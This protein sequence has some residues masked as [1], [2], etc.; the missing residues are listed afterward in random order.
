MKLK[1]DALAPSCPNTPPSMSSREK[2]LM[3]GFVSI[4]TVESSG[5]S[6]GVVLTLLGP[7]CSIDLV[8]QCHS[9]DRSK[10]RLVDAISNAIKDLIETLPDTNW[11]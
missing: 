6:I 4:L 3:I 8:T 11:F 7:E 9:C 5:M 2:K 10:N 1:I